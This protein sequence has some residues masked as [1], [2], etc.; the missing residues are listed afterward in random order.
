MTLDLAAIKAR[1]E[2]LAGPIAHWAGRADDIR[3][4]ARDVLA[5]VRELERA[6][7][8]FHPS[9]AQREAVA[10]HMAGEFNRRLGVP[11]TNE[12][13]WARFDEIARDNFRAQ[14]ADAWAA[15]IAS[16]KARERE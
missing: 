1:A 10:I 16:L 11:G 7:P 8:P 14:A 12:E 5:L 13:I 6:A 9:P 15:V 4:M 3:K 2:E